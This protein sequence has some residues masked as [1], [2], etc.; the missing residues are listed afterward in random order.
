MEAFMNDRALIVPLMNRLSEYEAREVEW[1]WPGRVPIG[2]VTLLCGDPGVGKSFICMDMAARVSVGM[3][4]P[5][6]GWE[7][8]PGTQKPK[9]S[10]GGPGDIATRAAEDGSPWHGDG[11]GVGGGVDTGVSKQ[12]PVAREARGSVL[13]MSAEDDPFDT[14]RPRVERAGGDVSRVVLLRGF[15]E[16]GRPG[17]WVA[18]LDHNMDV[19]GK[20]LAKVERPR[21]VV[22]DPVS[23]F[24]GGV[25]SY[26]NAAVRDVLDRLGDLAAQ[27]GIAVVCVTHVNKSG[28]VRA[29]YRV[30]GSLAFAA[31]P[32]VV[33]R[34][35]RLSDGRM[36]MVSVKSNVAGV[37]GAIAF[38]IEDGRLV[39]ERAEGVKVVEMEGEPRPME[40]AC[41][42]LREVLSAGPRGAA[43][44]IGEAERAGISVGTLR[45]AKEICGVGVRR[46]GREWEWGLEVVA[47]GQGG[48]GAAPS[49]LG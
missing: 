47:V 49:R 42:F 48:E 9:S 20:A 13:V 14:L 37:G 34:V 7:G 45:R 8:E 23:A 27:W 16:Y 29:A 10:V 3:G 43:E 39:W 4:W 11:A 41:E 24:L 21:L 30:M 35:A 44:V 32:R 46:V 1:L 12:P 2:K 6:E 38:R 19:I 15:G 36:G 25:N 17:A 18:T 28:G 31:S 26:S 5:E 22:I 40:R 33:W